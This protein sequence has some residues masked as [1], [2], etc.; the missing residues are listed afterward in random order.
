MPRK[1][2]TDPQCAELTFRTGP[3][4]E[5]RRPTYFNSES[6]HSQINDHTSFELILSFKSD[7]LSVPHKSVTIRRLIIY[8]SHGAP[9]LTVLTPQCLYRPI[10]V[11]L[12]V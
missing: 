6:T 7:K 5:E 4:P 10:D 2:R 12:H 1:L 3:G 8:L 11:H 9:S